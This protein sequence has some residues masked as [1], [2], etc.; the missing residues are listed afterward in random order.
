MD[1]FLEKDGVMIDEDWR[2]LSQKKTDSLCHKNYLTATNDV[3]SRSR[4]GSGE[5]LFYLVECEKCIIYK[6][7]IKQLS[8][9]E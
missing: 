8:V 3:S 4:S 1:S 7:F 9:N 2:C 5:L 6:T